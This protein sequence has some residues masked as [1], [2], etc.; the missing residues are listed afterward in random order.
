LQALQWVSDDVYSGKETVAD[1]ILEHIRDKNPNFWNIHVALCYLSK[2]LRPRRYLEIGTRRGRSL[3]QVLCNSDAS[4]VVCIDIFED[5]KFED[6]KQDVDSFLQRNKKNID[7][8]YCLE[9]SETA[10]KRLVE[11]QQ[12]FDL[13]TIDASHKYDDA[14]KDLALAYQLLNSTGVLII[15]D[16]ALF[17]D[18]MKMVKE[19]K[20]R[21]QE[22]ELIY[23][24]QMFGCALLY[25]GI[26]L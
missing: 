18:L 19:F 10:L 9:R 6:L 23:T 16:V 26:H 3:F 13:I 8:T 14:V 21:N 22:L 24:D 15:D 12:I 7:I 17:P 20:Q 5:S 1:A 11:Q 4:T 25:R 2:T